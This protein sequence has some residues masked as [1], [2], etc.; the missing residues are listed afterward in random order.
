MN[1]PKLDL[2]TAKFNLSFI[3]F[4]SVSEHFH[5]IFI[6]N[7]AGRDLCMEE[8]LVLSELAE[9]FLNINVAVMSARLELSFCN[10]RDHRV[11]IRFV[12]PCA[13]FVCKLSAYI[14]NSA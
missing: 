14:Q 13:Y 7:L 4:V 3:L 5:H 12:K 11:L 9:F 6:M 2:R 10:L 1:C 8:P